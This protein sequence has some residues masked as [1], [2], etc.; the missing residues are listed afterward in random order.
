MANRVVTLLLLVFFVAGAA[1][2]SA[3]AITPEERLAQ[4]FT[5]GTI[6]ADWFAP[7]FL[8]QVPVGQMQ[9]IVAQY[10]SLLGA[11]QEAEGSAPAFQLVFTQ[12]T[13][14]TQIVLDNEGRVAG[15]WL[16]PPQPKVAGIEE[17]LANFTALPGK[18][19]VLVAADKG[20][21]GAIEPNA[22]L[23]IGSAFKLA[24]LAALKDKVGA[25]ALAW[26]KVVTLD[27]KHISL[28]SG[29]LQ[30]WPVGTPLTLQTVASLMISISDNTATDMLVDIVG[31]EYVETYTER[32]RPF[33][34][35]R[36][37]FTLKNPAN[38]TLLGAYRQGDTPKRREILQTLQ[39]APLPDASLFSGGP[40]ALDIEWFFSVSELA[41][42]MTYVHDL[43][44][45]SINPGVASAANWQRVA[46]KGGSEPGVI[47]LTTW[48]LGHSGKS[49]VVSA[50]WNNAEPLDETRFI[51]LYG[52]LL[53]V[54]QEM[55]KEP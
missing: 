36:E 21:L 31:R 14:A 48:L 16:G 49:Y 17:A 41:N 9:A 19:S 3:N 4:I 42:L 27:T 35:T 11:Y 30:S 54:L 38:S 39:A 53:A 47:N 22:P 40:L 52:A 50:T 13:V 2:A 28:P 46:F 45:M 44:F 6:N 33:L 10:T 23:A 5:A 7:A 25:G 51:V 34:T 29:I 37:A 32:N 55:D 18:V 24:V 20:V 12:G 15:F 8:A 26:D 43:P 1:H